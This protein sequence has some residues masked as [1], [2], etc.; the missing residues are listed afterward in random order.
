[1]KYCPLPCET[2]DYIQASTIIILTKNGEENKLH[3]STQ[4][5]HEQI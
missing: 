2:K 5:G 4:L 3:I 1:M